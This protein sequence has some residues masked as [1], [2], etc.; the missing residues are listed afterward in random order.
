MLPEGRFQGSAYRIIRKCCA[1]E[2][3]VDIDGDACWQCAAKAGRRV[4]S[5]S[6]VHKRIT[7]R[8]YAAI[9]VMV[10]GALFGLA[11]LARWMR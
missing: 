5:R 4:F 10:L 7:M 8:G 2:N 3:E 1:C 9:F 11:V 6:P